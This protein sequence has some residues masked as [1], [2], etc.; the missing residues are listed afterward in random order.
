MIPLGCVLAAFPPGI[1]ELSG[2]G[3]KAALTN[4]KYAKLIRKL[5]N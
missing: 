2:T 3:S 4:K 1:G 5:Y